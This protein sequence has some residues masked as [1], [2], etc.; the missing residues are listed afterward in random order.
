VDNPEVVPAA[1]ATWPADDDIVFG[2]EV[3]GEYR[4]YPRQIMEVREMVND[5]LGGPRPGHSLLHACA[6][7]RRPI[8]PMTCP[9]GWS[10]RCC[11]PRAF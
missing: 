3:N 4:A 11:G 2:I 8:S 5:T 10:D 7:R 1:E 6:A 9:M